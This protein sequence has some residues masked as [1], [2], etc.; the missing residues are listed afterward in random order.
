[1][2]F[3]RMLNK[4]KL[5]KNSKK[6]TSS[7]LKK[8]SVRMMTSILVFSMLL[9]YIPVFADPPTL[10][11]D[12]EVHYSIDGEVEGVL[13]YGRTDFTHEDAEGIH[14]NVTKWA[15]MSTSWGRTEDGPYRGR[16]LLN[17]FLREFYSQIAS[18]E[19]NGIQFVKEANGALWKVPI[20]VSTFSSGAIGVVTNDEIIIKLKND[21]TLESLGLA[22][23]K[24]DF[25]TV[26][27]RRDNYADINGNDNGFILKNNPNIKPLPTNPD[28]GNEYY[29]AHKGSIA[30]IGVTDGTKTTDGLFTYGSL[31]KVVSYDAKNQ[32]IRSTVSFKPTENFLQANTGWVLYINEVIPQELLKYIDTDNVYLGTSDPQGNFTR[33]SPIRIVVDPNGSGHI[34]TKDT[35]ALSIVGGDWKKTDTVRKLLDNQV[36]WGT[37]GQRRSY[38]IQYKIKS[39]YSNI[40]LVAILNEYI[41]ANNNHLNFESWLEADFVDY[42]SVLAGSRHPDG[43]KPNKMLQNSYANGFLEVIDTDK[44]GLFDFV[45]D[46]IGSNKF[47][48]DSDGDGVPDNVEVLIDNTNPIDPKS[49][50]VVAPIVTTTKINANLNQAIIGTVPKTI[51]NNPANPTEQL[52][53]TNPDAGEVIVRAYLYVE[54]DTDYSDN[55]IKGQTTISFADLVDGNFTLN[56]PAGT[57]ADGDEVVLVAYSP[58]GNNPMI[59]LQTVLVGAYKVSFDVN[60][61]KWSDESTEDKLVEIINGTV[62]EP[63]APIKEGYEFLGWASTPS[64][65]TPE[66]GV[67]NN[68]TIDKEVFAIWKALPSVITNSVQEK[69]DKKPIDNIVITPGDPNATIVVETTKFPNGVIYNESPKT[70]SGT[71]NVIDWDNTEEFKVY[72]F[73]IVVNNTDGSTETKNVQITV[74]RDTDGDGTP[75]Y[76]DDDDDGDGILDVNDANPKVFDA[77]I[78]TTITRTVIEGQAVP[79]SVKAVETNKTSTVSSST[80]KGLSVDENGNLIGTP[81][82]IAWGADEEGTVVEI[83]V[84]V[85]SVASGST[86]TLQRT[87]TVNILRDTD[88]D[89]TPDYL[90]DDD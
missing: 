2:D 3:F 40:D 82:G 88:G 32:I 86:E 25:T 23:T 60:G 56:I 4:E 69:I 19:V 71:L 76:L 18:V 89:G 15:T 57:F 67:L 28:V 35:P 12:N 70:I 38:T 17:F 85:T 29:L 44:D 58:D 61:G 39:Q 49:Y 13:V 66:E 65:K 37:L 54:E 33:S 9:S 63:D 87:V 11:I 34:T 26:W 5:S 27:V 16:Y 50:L 48:V 83:P 79:A 14:L 84:T 74:L 31:T 90:D 21:A 81:T 75:D 64:A 52:A 10:T 53:A 22:D 47:I 80:V 8:I 46:E 62:I 42:T 78:A 43:G 36:F 1:M 59:S 24:I 72:K 7:K 55:E 30:S 68:L 20:N 51:H 41:Q 73:N 77:L 45:E 6:R